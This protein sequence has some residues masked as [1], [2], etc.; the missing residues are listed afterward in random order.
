MNK[1][2]ERNSK[3]TLGK[4][5]DDKVNKTAKKGKVGK[6]DESDKKKLRLKTREIVSP[7]ELKRLTWI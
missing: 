3:G 6:N 5:G 1:A 4:T 2:V 7:K